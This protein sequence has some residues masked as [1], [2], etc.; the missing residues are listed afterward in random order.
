MRAVYVAVTYLDQTQQE[1]SRVAVERLCNFDSGAT[2]RALVKLKHLNYLPGY[3][4][5]D[6]EL[7]KNTHAKFTTDT[8]P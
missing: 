6:W 5:E 7:E 2:W 8:R 1:V 3:R 4:V